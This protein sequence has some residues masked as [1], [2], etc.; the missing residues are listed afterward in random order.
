MGV[1]ENLMARA[2][3]LKTQQRNAKVSTDNSVYSDLMARANALNGKQQIQPT[4]QQ[5]KTN[6]NS[7]N[8]QIAAK[9]NEIADLWS[10][11]DK[12]AAMPWD[13][14]LQQK[15]TAGLA[16]LGS[17]Q[18]ELDALNEKLK[19][20]EEKQRKAVKTNA[21]RDE[22]RSNIKNAEE[23]S[24]WA[25]DELSTANMGLENAEQQRKANLEELRSIDEQLGNVERPYDDR[26]RAGYTVGGALKNTGASI[27][28]AGTTF[29]DL[30]SK[31]NSQNPYLTTE[32][33]GIA[34]AMGVTPEEY[35]K[36][37][38][39]GGSGQARQEAFEQYYDTADRLMQESAHDIAVAKTDLS[40]LG[41]AGVDLS[42][43]LVQMGADAA[44]RAIGLGMLPF[45]TR[46]A[47][48]SAYEARQDGATL[49]QRAAYGALKGA[50]EV[51]T[52]KLFDGVAG[53]FGKGAAD[54]VV[55]S[56]V[57]KLAKTNNGRTALRALAGAGGEGT[58]EVI[59]DL[60]DPFAKLI[61]N[62]QALKEAW[63]NRK[64]LASD[65]LYDYLIGFAMGGLGS[66][67]SIITGQD[68]QKNAALRRQDIDSE[69][70]SE[71]FDI[72]QQNALDDIR[73][74]TR[75]RELDDLDYILGLATLEEVKASKAAK[76][77]TPPE[78]GTAASTRNE[79]VTV[80]ENLKNN[81]PAMKEMTPVAETNS[82][83]VSSTPGRTMVEKAK[84][85]FEKIKGTVTRAGF[86]DVEINNRSVKDDTAHGIGAAKA[87]VIPAIPSV[88]QNGKQ[89]DFQQ[90]WKGRPYDGYVFAAP[91]NLDG[92]TVY[93]AAVVK[94]TSKNKFYLH[95]VVD[96]DG[97]IIKMNDGEK[98]NQTSLA[99]VDDA[100]ALSPSISTAPNGTAG[101]A[102]ASPAISIPA[103][104]QNVNRENAPS[105]GASGYANL[106]EQYGAI[107]AGEKPF[108][109]ST[110]PQSTTGADRVSRTARTIY[111]AEATPEAR[112]PSLESAVVDKKFS[113]IPVANKDLESK[114]R[115]KIEE[116][117]WQESLM[118]WTAE[119]RSGKSNA[120][121]V[122][123][124]A[125]LLNNAGNSGMSAEQYIDLAMDYD[126]LVH[127]SASATQ[128][129]RI[130]KNLSPEAKLYGLRRSAKK[131][132]EDLTA[133]ARKEVD[134]E[135]DESLIQKFLDQTTDE[136]RNVV[137]DEIRQNIADQIPA[138]L[139]EKFDA[140]R[141]VNMLGNFKTQIRNVVGN[142]AM[143][144][145]RTVKDK[146]AALLEYAAYAASGGKFE[147]TKSLWTGGELRKEA[148]ADFENIAEAAKGESKYSSANRLIDKEIQD[149][150][151]IFKSNVLEAYRKVT[152]WAMDKGD[153]IFLKAAYS[154]ALT[155]WLRAHG[156]KSISEAT[157]EQLD[158]GRAYAIK[159]A[160]EAT[161]RD[162][163]AVS[164]FASDFDK[165]WNP[166]FKKVT[167]GIVPFRKTPANVAVRAVEYSPLGIAQ[168][169]YKGIQASNKNSDVTGADV[170]NSLAKT[171][172]GSALFWAG[173]Q[174]A[175]MG[176]ARGTDDDEDEAALAKAQGRLDWSVRIGDKDVSLSQLAPMAIP[177]FM[178]ARFQE[179]TK[180]GFEP[181][182]L[183]S[184]LMATITEPM[185]EMSMLQ[186]V[187]DALS[188]VSKF[189]TDSNAVGNL[190]MNSLF[191][192]L[193]QGLTNSL[194]SQGEQAWEKN[195]QTIYSD[196]E[197]KWLSSNAQYKLGKW[198]S[199]V[200]GVDYHQQDY[201]DAFGQ[202]QS[203]GNAGER[204][205]NAFLN[206]FYSSNIQAADVTDELNRLAADNKGAD[207]FPDIVPKRPAR[208]TKVNGGILSPDEYQKYA[209]MKGDLSL[210]M[211]QDAMMSKAYRDMTDE[212]KAELI[213]DIYSYATEQAGKDIAKARGEEWD[214]EKS[215]AKKFLQAD[216][217]MDAGLSFADWY[218]VRNAGDKKP[219]DK[220]VAISDLY[221]MDD[222]E[223]LK[224]LEVFFPPDSES[225][226][227]Q[228]MVKRYEAAMAAGI[229]FDAW[230]K[231]VERMAAVGNPTKREYIIAA[232]D[233]VYPGQ[234]RALYNIW[235]EYPDADKYSASVMPEGAD[236]VLWITGNDP[237][238]KKT[239]QQKDDEF[240]ALLAEATGGTSNKGMPGVTDPMNEDYLGWL[241]GYYD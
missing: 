113:Y 82:A 44:G 55:E 109:E 203:N 41:Q 226:K 180:D 172:T 197:N 12:A 30:M 189:G 161:F 45:F 104:G 165:N 123:M 42:V 154:D 187:N 192:Y 134:I 18:R 126:M 23:Y 196:S 95:E 106:A 155:G 37:K 112:L 105:S 5:A 68:A 111:E 130:L 129:A 22:L 150:R 11:V 89:I 47:G 36:M 110:M 91:V 83:I 199:R 173:L 13:K 48:G 43:N 230:T 72:E 124:G 137:I 81:I 49:E 178:G 220:A 84:V 198:L 153:E 2:N 146:A 193:T 181:A 214:M 143:G 219:A 101:E 66:G 21:R 76:K 194:L 29:A 162:T 148:A 204:I 20:A 17:K 92:K 231:L 19:A 114:A 38:Q 174:L 46:A 90:N 149:K 133:K 179:L 167:Q 195:R 188:D 75:T 157:E 208:T 96:S 202:T 40:A 51:G 31:Y 9:N 238:Q 170:V 145:T 24:G 140:L 116:N 190:V 58:E 8:Q 63:E 4:E 74:Q 169:V 121:L 10:N 56:V 125:T 122:A 236:P 127:N 131:I 234:G 210:G 100:G 136:G 27:V 138:T 217:A 177:F 235:K 237:S 87:A 70:S 34:R 64:D 65:M 241:L 183:Q 88:I 218:N 209:A 67:G 227:R 60:L 186:G 26:Q 7:I 159:E 191:N 168:T 229:E 147:R 103:S 200:P 99:P 6:V 184:I 206:P 80:V 108:R 33:F 139:A 52:E 71:A 141:Y 182:D 107:P 233:S 50:I 216:E 117:G 240:Y 69:L 152:N 93:V 97:N 61:Y 102:V 207:G 211:L 54:D 158:A 224:A 25:T 164:K 221:G 232:L 212:Q 144:L 85:L 135:I 185:L 1:Y 239:Q 119:V 79:S 156:I 32:E 228:A 35:L 57:R 163:N 132:S 77:I 115:K 39:R 94:Q 59:S 128:A 98:V 175:K 166:T 176:L 223:K 222:G 151:R 225:G 118:D 62:D 205:F 28:E 14:S 215:N 3:S 142:V 16:G 120:R 53:I 73:G 86:G 15:A 171:M 78:N 213:S 160:Q 201:L